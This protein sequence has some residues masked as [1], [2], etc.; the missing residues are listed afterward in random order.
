MTKVLISWIPGASQVNESGVQSLVLWANISIFLISFL[1]LFFYIYLLLTRDRKRNEIRLRTLLEKRA[2]LEENAKKI[3]LE[4]EQWVKEVQQF[5]TELENNDVLS[6]FIY[7]H[8]L[9]SSDSTPFDQNKTIQEF[10]TEIDTMEGH[11]FEHWCAELLQR[12]GFYKVEVTPGSGDHGVDILAEK[13]SIR[14]AIQCK[15]YSSNLGNTPIQEVY[16]GKE[17]YRCHVGAVITNRYFTGGGAA[18]AKATG[19]LLWDRDWIART[20]KNMMDNE[21]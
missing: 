21:G 9:L 14:Y 4:L 3:E 17:M 5:V 19:V 16:A 2:I 8:P 15:C 7:E 20:L 1:I 11:D 12:N 18:L 13:D 10:L 6:A